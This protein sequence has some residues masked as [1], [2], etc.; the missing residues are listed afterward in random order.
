[1]NNMRN[2]L[3]TISVI[4][5]FITM[6]IAN[7]L[8][9]EIRPVN[10]KLNILGIQTI[11]VNVSLGDSITNNTDINLNTEKIHTFTI[12]ED[13]VF[14]KI[15]ISI[16]DMQDKSN[17]IISNISIENKSIKNLSNCIIDGAESHLVNNT[18]VLQPTSDKI[19]ITCPIS[20]K[21]PIINFHLSKFLLS[22]TVIYGFFYI[23]INFFKYFGNFIKVLAKK[24]CANNLN[25]F[26]LSVSIC[27]VLFLFTLFLLSY[28]GFI[29]HIPIQK[30]YILIATLV[31]IIFLYYFNKIT[32]LQ[33]KYILLQISLLFFIFISSYFFANCFYD[34]S[35]D[36]RT[37]HQEI[38]ILL[39]NG[40]N[41]IFEKPSSLD[42]YPS[43]WCEHYPKCAEILSANFITIFKNIE[44]GKIINFLFS[45][46]IFL[47]SF[48]TFNKFKNSNWLLS[49]IMSILIILN[50]VAICQ[51]K[52][53]YV[54]LLVYYLFVSILFSIILKEKNFINNKL[55]SFLLILEIPILCNIKLGGIF[56]SILLILSY[57]V[58]LLINKN[59][60]D[61][62]LLN[63]ITLL[64]TLLILISGINPYY[65]NIKQGYNVIY[66]LVGEDKID[67]IKNQSPQ[68]FEHKNS[69]Y[70]LF[71]S[72]FSNSKNILYD[73]IEQPRIKIPFS[74]LNQ[75]I[76][77][78]PDM[79]IAGFGYFWGGILLL[80][81]PFVILFK[82]PKENSLYYY[83]MSILWLSILINPQSWWA[84]YAPQF[85]LIPIFIIFRKL[86]NNKRK[87][88]LTCYAFILIMLLFINSLIIETQV[89]IN[90]FKFTKERISFFKKVANKNIDIY[91]LGYE[92][93]QS[94]RYKLKKLNTH[95]NF[96]NRSEYEKNS[97]SFKDIPYFLGTGLYK[98]KE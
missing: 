39:I 11:K 73:T 54:D 10:I 98:I 5:T 50:P 87:K 35:W 14:N 4:L 20:P 21:Y 47:L 43:I 48:F 72:T 89:D 37:Y 88:T 29:C 92:L 69:I 63:I 83:I 84:R 23:F 15:Q 65:T 78:I 52:T 59:Y 55:F 66:P 24:K 40:W 76:L 34:S 38:I 1:M 46:S 8:F 70:K 30:T 91:L 13:K 64:S 25:L 68:S 28:I 62:K 82:N 45:C 32:Q 22:F 85:W 61:I 31:S 27:I 90:A 94:L 33:Q 36:G 6:I 86:L 80:L 75:D 3:S 67:I 42:F 51:I 57:Y 56:Y 19:L 77:C 58:Y 26:C 96:I 9:I 2:L 41:P 49:L 60:K 71:V 81:I 16:N 44:S 17:I 53:Y 12:K 79:R 18:L 97:T 74:I 7:W 95:Y 93:E